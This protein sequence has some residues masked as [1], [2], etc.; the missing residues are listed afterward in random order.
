M[1]GQD[2]LEE[3]K[4]GDLFSLPIISTGLYRL[5]LPKGLTLKPSEIYAEI[6]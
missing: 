4:I 1:P 6:R 5:Y 3:F 2:E